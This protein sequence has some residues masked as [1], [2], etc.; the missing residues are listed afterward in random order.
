[1]SKLCCF[2]GVGIPPIPR[3]SV[4]KRGL[5]LAKSRTSRHPSVDIG[6]SYSLTLTC[7]TLKYSVDLRLRR[8]IA[9]I[10]AGL[11]YMVNLVNS[12][13]LGKTLTP[14]TPRSIGKVYDVTDFLDG[15]FI[16]IVPNLDEC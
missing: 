5:G 2:C 4:E 13:T 11:S 15:T 10:A 16:A 3:F 12:G 6:Q 7:Q 9:E 1:M 8:I 14:F